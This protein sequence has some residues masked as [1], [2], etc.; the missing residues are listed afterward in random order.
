[1]QT[2]GRCMR[3]LAETHAQAL[4]NTFSLFCG[5]SAN[6]SYCKRK[7][8]I[9]LLRETYLLYHITMEFYHISLYHISLYL[10]SLYHMALYLI[11]L[12]YIALYCVTLNHIILYY[13]T[14]YHITLCHITLYRIT[15]Y[16]I[17][18][19]RTVTYSTVPYNCTYNPVPF[20]TANTSHT[21]LLT[22]IQ[23]AQRTRITISSLF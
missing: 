8:F 17:P 9:S 16:H 23:N 7:L 21:K 20:N 15:L 14:L 10:I 18:P 5:V 2:Q 6:T 19:C 4:A 3:Q 1:M 12:Y 11:S 22:N 13:I